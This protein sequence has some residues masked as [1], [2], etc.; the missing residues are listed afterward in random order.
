MVHVIKFYFQTFQTL[1]EVLNCLNIAYSEPFIVKQ[2]DGKH[3]RMRG[4]Q[5][6]KTKTASYFLRAKLRDWWPFPIGVAKGP[7]SP[8]LVRAIDSKIFGGRRK[9]PSGPFTGVTSTSSQ[10]MGT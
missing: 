2:T 3:T 9:F 5:E 7:F 8:T 10:S 4:R 1:V 6:Q